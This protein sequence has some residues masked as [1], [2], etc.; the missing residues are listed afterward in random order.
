MTPQE[1]NKAI[2][3]IETLVIALSEANNSNTLD[4]LRDVRFNIRMQ[5]IRNVLLA[6]EGR[7]DVQRK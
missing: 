6:Y 7:N 4:I 1:Y 3:G 5:E 2:A